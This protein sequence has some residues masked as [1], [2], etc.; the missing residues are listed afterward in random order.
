MF[1]GRWRSIV[2]LRL[3]SLLRRDRV[4]HELDEELRFHI[5]ERA[6]ELAAR[7]LDPEEARRAALKGF[8][9]LEQ[10]KEDCRDRRRVGWI[11]DAVSDVRGALR[12]MRRTPAFTIV[13]ILS[14]ALGIGANTAIFSAVDTVIFRTLPLS[15]PEQLVQL[16]WSAPAF[17]EPFAQTLEGGGGRSVGGEATRGDMF[18]YMAW[19]Q[20]QA[21]HPGL[22]SVIGFTADTTQANV[23]AGGTA[24]SARL[25][26]V[27]GNYFEALGLTTSTGRLLVTTDD[28]AASVPSAV[29]SYAFWQ[30]TLGGRAAIGAPLVINGEPFT[31]VGIAPAFFFGLEPGV[32]VDLFVP[33]AHYA[34]HVT[35]REGERLPYLADSTLWWIRL[36]A[37]RD[38]ATPPIDLES[39]I[40]A[41]FRDSIGATQAAPESDVPAV[42]V[43]AIPGGID[44]MQQ[45][46]RPSLVT[47]MWMVAMVL[48][49]ACANVGGLLLDRGVAR[50][51]EIAVRLSLGIRRSRLIRQLMTESLVLSLLGGLGALLLTVWTYPVLMS[52]LSRAPLPEHLT[53]AIDYRLLAFT[54]AVSIGSGAV[55]GLAPVLAASHVRLIGAL[56]ERA[57]PSSVRGLLIGKVLVAAQLAVALMLSIAA[58]LFG[59]TL[60]Q[61]HGANL[62]FARQNLLL[63]TVQPGSNG[64]AGPRL[65]AYYAELHR[66]IAA[67]PGVAAATM[68][69]RPAVG[70]GAGS[71][72]AVLRG[73]SSAEPQML[74]RHEIGPRYFETLGVTILA[75]RAL[76][77]RDS[78]A[79]PRAMVINETL[80]RTA[81]AGRDPIGSRIEF[82]G[83]A[84][85]SFE[86]VGV[87]ADVKYSRI[88][89][90]VPPTVYLPYQQFFATLGSMSFL[91]RSTVDPGPLL[92]SIQ[93]E[94][95]ALDSAVP[96]TNVRT[97]IEA[98]DATLTAERTFAVFSAALGALALLLSAIGLFGTMRHAVSRRRNEI[99]VRMALGARAGT[100]VW[101]V[102]SES[103][104]IAAA[105]V[106]LGLGGAYFGTQLIASQLFGIE[107]H[108]SVTLISTTAGLVAVTALA[109]A[110][111]A[112]QAARID[113]MIALR[114]D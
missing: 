51:R 79:A 64:Y 27:T 57:S 21:S 72:G 35:R 55:F 12:L 22:N 28:D 98:I 5:D 114:A 52:L 49:I 56:R 3:R 42:E 8:G 83:T 61:L 94:A 103:L 91:V 85:R 101:M 93:R 104:R 76:D 71:S 9:G 105:G 88:R 14:L 77:Q 48:V 40:T 60:S 74:S 108:D 75:G 11:E 34:R 43:H 10:R 95:L 80:A 17:P 19:Q 107:A 86:I 97:Q 47:L 25:L 109:A 16:Q 29:V 111:P 106:T 54:A 2:R 82:G 4:E 65:D 100:V 70:G 99:G 23:S 30:S 89:S 20:L 13:A 63:F 87:A 1:S 78:R 84:E 33:V 112:R 6:R 45:A 26:A 62:G 18:P 39:R 110:L 73:A 59:S 67:L 7:G 15:H 92:A 113:P 32:A 66:R 53:L 50:E 102:L 37:V 81:F 24:A 69:R 36:V 44:T 90:A 58:V 96:I 38:S 41:I 46:L 31:L 68:A